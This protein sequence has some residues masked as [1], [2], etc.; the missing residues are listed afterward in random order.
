M[1]AAIPPERGAAEQQPAR[2]LYLEDPDA[3]ERVNE[4]RHG[5]FVLH[6]NAERLAVAH[7]DVPRIVATHAGDQSRS[8]RMHNTAK[9]LAEIGETGL[10]IDWAQRGALL[11]TG[12]Q[13]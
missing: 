9:A 7:R 12:H 13:G 11:E 2:R 6:Y 1:A 4:H 8:Y 10:A 5:R 3:W